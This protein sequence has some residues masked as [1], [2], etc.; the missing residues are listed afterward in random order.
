VSLKARQASC[1]YRV[2]LKLATTSSG[3]T[4]LLILISPPR[5]A[6]TVLVWIT[7]AFGTDLVKNPNFVHLVTSNNM[8]IAVIYI[9]RD[10]HV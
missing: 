9:G 10:F 5:P 7:E 6:K 1:E 8:W 3:L 2:D 4:H